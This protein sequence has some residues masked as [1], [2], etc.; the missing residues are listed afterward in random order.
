M[1]SRTSLRAWHVVAGQTLGFTVIV[2]AS[3]QGY[4]AAAFLPPPV[5]GL[6]GVLPL[7]LGVAGLREWPD[8]VRVAWGGAAKDEDEENDEDEVAATVE[9]GAEAKP[10]WWRGVA[11]LLLHPH[12]L[13]VAL[14]ALSNGSDNLSIY[15][16]LLAQCTATELAVTVVVFYAMLAVWLGAAA[17]FVSAPPVARFIARFGA[18]GVPFLLMGLGVYILID[19]GTVC[20]GADCTSF[21]PFAL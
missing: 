9:G 1:K 20:L 6:L 12:I 13:N 2:A 8:A 21:F 11:V 3:A 7:A 18:L 5:V 17:A 10:A 16:P 19:A 4:A 14:T 15:I